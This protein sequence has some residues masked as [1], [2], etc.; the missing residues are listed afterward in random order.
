MVDKA[1]LL[2]FGL[3]F[4]KEYSKPP[5]KRYF[6]ITNGY[7]SYGMV[8]KIFGS[9]GNFLLELGFVK[10]AQGKTII[11]RELITKDKAISMGELFYSKYKELPTT[12]DPR[13]SVKNGF[14]T[15]KDIETTF[16]S[17]KNFI[18]ELKHASSRYIQKEPSIDIKSL[19]TL[20]LKDYTITN[21]SFTK[22][23]YINCIIN[24][25]NTITTLRTSNKVIKHLNAT[26]YPLLRKNQ[27]VVYYIANYYGY[28]HCNSCC[29]Y[30]PKSFFHKN[31]Q[32]NINNISYTC[33]S[34]DNARKDKTSSILYANKRRAQCAAVSFDQKGIKE[35]YE[36]CPIDHH[37]DHIIPLTHRSVCGLH[38]LSN[39]QYL[40][41]TDNLTKSNKFEEWWDV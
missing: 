25:Q 35:F 7:A 20:Y 23:E 27:P 12:K 13:W 37:V 8:V 31:L 10:D 17:W 32:N 1:L 3:K 11:K 33:K 38:V 28:S 41:K 5:V 29:E 26:L 15:I 4:Y 30:Y 22:E 39:L 34:C 18:L 36:A 14:C 21:K 19:V 40:Y 2:D 16:N 24:K 9:W 6:T